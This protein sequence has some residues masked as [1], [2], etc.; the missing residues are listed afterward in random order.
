[1]KTVSWNKGLKGEKYKQHYKKF[2]GIADKY[3]L[4]YDINWLT[5]QYYGFN[6]TTDEMAKKLGCTR[7]TIVN[8]LHKSNIPIRYTNFDM[9][10]RDKKGKKQCPNCQRWLPQNSFSKDK[11]RGD[12]LCW[13]CKE[14]SNLEEERNKQ[15]N[16]IITLQI[17]TNGKMECCLC[18]EDDIDVLSFD[19][20][21]NNGN[22]H[23][24]EIKNCHIARW[25]IRN[26]F[27]EGYRVLCRNCNWKDRLL[28][29]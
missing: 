24:K 23:R 13:W 19:H 9:W 15:I 3:H 6:L 21:Y 16:R 29:K 10:Q 12:N 18:G 7:K 2:K 17:Y 11:R 1:M 20:I 8:G 28:R 5:E 14:C 22:I 4:A 25:L 26:N 27:P